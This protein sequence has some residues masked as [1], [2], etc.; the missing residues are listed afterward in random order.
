MTSPSAFAVTVDITP[1]RP[2]PLFGY[3][4]RRETHRGIHRGL[5]ANVLGISGQGSA[6]LLLVSVDALYGGAITPRLRK[7][8]HLQPDQLVVFGSHTHFAPGIDPG[9]PSL[10]QTDPDYL[11]EVVEKVATAVEAA[12]HERNPTVGYASAATQGL[13]VNRR[14]PTLGVGLPVPRIG[15]IVAAPHVRGGVD[16]KVRVATVE[17]AGRVV[18]LLWGASCHPV[19]SPDP[20]SVS[21]DFPG[22][23]R[24]RLRDALGLDLPVVFLQ[25]FSADVRPAT[26][27][28]RAPTGARPFLQYVL[29]GGRRF[30]RQSATEYAEWCGALTAVVL[31][32]VRDLASTP[33]EAVIGSVVRVAPSRPHGWER[34]AQLSRIRL[35]SG[36]SIVAVNAEVGHQRVVDLEQS[37]AEAT[38][39][40]GCCD[41]VIGYWPTDAMVREG[42]YEGGDAARYFPVLDWNSVQGPDALWRELLHEATR[43]S[44]EPAVRRGSP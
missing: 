7:R 38:I 33:R 34:A 25:G 31:R 2:L 40:A 43:T 35:S 27:S 9:I 18:A 15:R 20:L 24:A 4:Q 5:E 17:V 1:D 6:P 22:E 14:R 3:H 44:E 30:V 13:F 26:Q 41:E 36:V 37:F 28:R 10:G 21:P 16:A 29:A 23:I 32:A 8:L 12:H 39:P 11:D 42:G 19:A